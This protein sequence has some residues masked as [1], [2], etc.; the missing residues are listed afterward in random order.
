MREVISINGKILFDALYTAAPL[1][2][3]NAKTAGLITD[4][5]YSRPS[6]LPDCQLLLG[7]KL[8]IIKQGKIN[9]RVAAAM[10]IISYN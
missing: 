3:P 6:W 9:K 7:G 10:T 5:C 1:T 2:L 4:I 8:N